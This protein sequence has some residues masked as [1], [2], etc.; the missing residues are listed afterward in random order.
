MFRWFVIKFVVL[1]CLIRLWAQ[2][3][4]L[5]KNIILL[6]LWRLLLIVSV[7]RCRCF[8]VFLSKARKKILFSFLSNFRFQIHLMS[9]FFRLFL[10]SCLL[11]RLVFSLRFRAIIVILSLFVDFAFFRKFL[12]KI[13]RFT[14]FFN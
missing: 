12:K 10:M 5:S 7:F 8:F 2:Q 11:F 9:C 1:F 13:S 14:L 4:H 3:Y 6:I